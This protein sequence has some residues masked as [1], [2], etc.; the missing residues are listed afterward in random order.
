MHKT[1]EKRREYDRKWREAN[2]ERIR[3]NAQ[4]WRDENREHVRSEKRK[5]YDKNKESAV[6]YNKKRYEA[7]KDKI[8][9]Q[10]RAYRASHRDAI[11]VKQREHYYK[12]KEVYKA[13]R[14][15]W[16]ANNRHKVRENIRRRDAAKLQRTPKWLTSDDIWLM[17]EIYDL[18]V[19]RE[20]MTGFAW[21]VDHIIPLQGKKV[22]GLH[23]PNNL[24]VIP[25]R[26]NISK[27]N[28]Y[29][30]TA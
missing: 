17:K 6:E 30:E 8:I 25:G 18:A 16:V 26:D 7:H 2:R 28:R 14:Q 22:S 29:D 24:Q 1:P 13:N 3:A 15:K 10:N 27:G 5:W 23:V 4:K 20:K 19:K 21:H 11:I 9:A 12:Y